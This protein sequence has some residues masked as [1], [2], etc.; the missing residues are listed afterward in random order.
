MNDDTEV[1]VELTMLEEAITRAVVAAL[2][3]DRIEKATAKFETEATRA[4]E[5]ARWLAR[6]T[7]WLQRL[8]IKDLA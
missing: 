7:E 5:H 8:E 6:E 2:R 3:Q 4:E 1:M